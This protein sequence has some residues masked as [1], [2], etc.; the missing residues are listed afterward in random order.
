[1][2]CF[3]AFK[4]DG[5][6]Y[7][8]V[9]GDTSVRYC[10]GCTYS[11]KGA[12][13]ESVET[14]KVARLGHKGFHAALKLVDVFTPGFGYSR[15]DPVLVVQLDPRH[16]VTDGIRA[17]SSTMTLLE[18][19]PACAV[20][21]QV[22]GPHTGRCGETL[23]WMWDG[24]LHRDD[25]NPALVSDSGGMKWYLHGVLHRDHDAPAVIHGDGSREWWV[26]G[27]RHCTDGSNGSNTDTPA[28]MKADGRLEWWVHGT[29]HRDLTDTGIQLP[30]VIS[31]DGDMV[32]MWRGRIH[33]NGPAPAVVHDGGSKA[34]VFMGRQYKYLGFDGVRE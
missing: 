30:A 14:W 33:R 13:D 3:K 8:T 7:K 34:W 23:F 25:D 1:M 28:V 18:I 2:I 20:T 10:L 4:A 22:A 21:A 12:D 11:V 31:A 6:N 9:R 15:S 26:H 24:V 17:C 16:F 32:W 29:R 5:E 19:V 27:T